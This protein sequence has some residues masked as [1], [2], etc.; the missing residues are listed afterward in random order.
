M[1]RAFFAIA[2]SIGAAVVTAACGS[3]AGSGIYGS[4]NPSTGSTG[5]SAAT[6]AIA[7]TNLGKILVDGNGKTLY[8]FEAD[9]GSA[10]SCYDSCLGVWPA[11]VTSGSP[12]A[13][14]G[15][16]AGLLS[17]TKRT[18]GSLEVVYNGHPLY[19]F[20]GD[21]Q[22]GDVTGQDLN[23]FGALWFVLS[24]AGTKIG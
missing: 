8:L 15:V 14:P 16:N 17:T 3:S 20:S 5:T 21:K 22:A 24:P 19:Y 11:L 12:L 13:G 18:D 10:S 2:A 6:V 4:N 7:S 9:K 1:S 23:S